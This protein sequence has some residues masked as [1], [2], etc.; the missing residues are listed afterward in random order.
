MKLAL[1]TA[2]FKHVS[3]EERQSIIK[4]FMEEFKD[5]NDFT[6]SDI[7]EIVAAFLISVAYLSDAQVYDNDLWSLC[8][9]SYPEIFE[10]FEQKYK[11]IIQSWASK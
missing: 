9:T 6:I 1:L 3:W 7:R 4:M 8:K 5:N 11:A 10:K 2:I